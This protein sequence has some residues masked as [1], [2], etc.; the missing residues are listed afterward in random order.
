VRYQKALR[1]ASGERNISMRVQKSLRK[2]SGERAH[3]QAN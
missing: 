2:A 1:K 3:R